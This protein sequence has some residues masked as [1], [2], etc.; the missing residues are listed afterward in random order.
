MD[1][2]G[3]GYDVHRLEKGYDC[4]LGGVKIRYE[5]GLKGHSDAD[6]LL[7]AICDALLG[8][9]GEGDIGRH[10][11][12]G[13]ARWEGISSLILLEEVLQILSGKGYRPVNCDSVVIAEAP[14]IFPFVEEMKK[15]I[16]KALAIS[17]ECVN[18][19]GTTNEQIGFIGRGEGIAAQAVCMITSS[20]PPFQPRHVPG[21]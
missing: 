17:P 13:D 14:R 2:I 11:R 12:A 1:R 21:N 6:V 3:I 20:K 7:H 16:S 19:K 10:F 5:K 15:N 8:A 4:I 18:V 9:A